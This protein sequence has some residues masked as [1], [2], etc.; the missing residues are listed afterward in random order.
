DVYETVTEE[1]YQNLVRDRQKKNDFVVDDEG[2]GYADDGEEYLDDIGKEEEKGNGKR[3]GGGKSAAA[4]KR[5]RAL[6]QAAAVGTGSITK[7]L[8]TSGTG[9]GP[10]LSSVATAK[11]AKPVKDLDI[12]DMLDGTGETEDCRLPD[13]S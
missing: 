1:Q 7:Y 13:Y 12:D 11:A 4:R 6:N 9:V 2:L 8:Q 3:P 10:G 5:A